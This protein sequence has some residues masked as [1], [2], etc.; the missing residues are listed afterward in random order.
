MVPRAVSVRLHFV[1]DLGMMDV[2]FDFV[3]IRVGLDFQIGR[4]FVIVNECCL[5][6]C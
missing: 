4:N 3:R 6:I 2:G 1:L 5:E